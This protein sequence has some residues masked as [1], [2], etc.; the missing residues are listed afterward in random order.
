ME[1]K[2]ESGAEAARHTKGERTRARLLEAAMHEFARNGF[3]ETKVSDIVGRA[4]LSQ[5]SFYLYFANKEAAYDELV[6][7]FRERMLAALRRIRFAGDFAPG[8]AHEYVLRANTIFFAALD[9]NPE[10]TEIGLFQP[11][12]AEV[13]KDELVRAIAGNVAAAQESGLFRRDVPPALVAQCLLGM[14][15]RVFRAGTEGE[16]RREQVAAIAA[17]LTDGLRNRGPDPGREGSMEDGTAQT[18]NASRIS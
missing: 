13:T 12:A 1:A 3:H 16:G 15:E 14:D 6:A 17:L 7:C 11:P 8:Q 9:E 10:L 2:E 5:P 18:H 4:G